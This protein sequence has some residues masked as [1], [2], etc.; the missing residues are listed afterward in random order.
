MVLGERGECGAEGFGKVIRKTTLEDRGG[1]GRKAEQ[2]H[3]AW[4]NCKF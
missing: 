3:V 1:G 4:R 2:K